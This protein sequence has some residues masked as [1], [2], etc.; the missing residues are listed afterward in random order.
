MRDSYFNEISEKQ[1][2]NARIY[3]SRNTFIDSLKDDI[4]YLE[5]GAID[6]NLAVDLI[7]KIKVKRIFLVG[8]FNNLDPE[9]QKRWKTE[10]ENYKFILDR[11]K[12][13]K[14]TFIV[15]KNIDKFLSYNSGTFNFIYISSSNEYEKKE[16]TLGRSI[17]LLENN[18]IIGMSDYNLA[19]FF[20]LR[21]QDWYIDSIIMNENT[22]SEIYI[23]KLEYYSFIN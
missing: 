7:E 12:S 13:I 19:K 1:I 21:N 6:G 3:G 17:L 18:G 10:E 8:T 14:N 5:L 11:F 16:I 4:K 20:L 9:N 15:K 2:K 22:I 23:K